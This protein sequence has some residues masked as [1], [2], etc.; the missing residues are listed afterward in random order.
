MDSAS[1]NKKSHKK[2]TSIIPT[3]DEQSFLG[4]EGKELLS[5][6]K[7]VEGFSRT[8]LPIPEWATQ[9][10]YFAN[11]SVKE[12]QEREQKNEDDERCSDPSPIRPY[13][14]PLHEDLEGKLREWTKRQRQ[15]VRIFPFLQQLQIICNG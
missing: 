14:K 7:D 13:L 2:R 10:T 15:K 11:R 12:K 5:A 1:D 9:R 8:Q 4:S 3:F 6:L